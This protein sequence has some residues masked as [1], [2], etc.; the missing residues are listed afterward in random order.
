MS[1]ALKKDTKWT[2]LELNS[3]PIENIQKEV[4][5]YEAEWDLDTSRQDKNLTHRNTK[6]YQLKYSSYDWIPGLEIN[7]S[8]INSFTSKESQKE[9][10]DI[11]IDLEKKYNGKVIRAELIK[12]MPNVNIRK[13]VDGGEFL[14][15]AR[16]CHV[17]INTNEDV[18]FTVLD[19]RIN[20]KEG[21]AYEIN[22]SLPHSVD[23]N[24]NQERDHLIL[25]IMPLELLVS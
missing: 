2:I 18:Y 22:N 7:V 13:H 15:Y 1:K 14:K 9:F 8:D 10:I 11:I 12:M 21:V 3:Y 20:M 5:S 17:P 16:R 19:N 23:N 25:D 6:M 4:S 24:S